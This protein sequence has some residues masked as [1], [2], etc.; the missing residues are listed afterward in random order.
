[1]Q[2]T[3]ILSAIKCLISAENAVEQGGDLEQRLHTNLKSLRSLL[4]RPAPESEELQKTTAAIR[5][6][7]GACRL[8]PGHSSDC[9]SETVHW[10]FA[11]EG[12]CLLQ[13][14]DGTL[15]TLAKEDEDGAPAVSPSPPPAPKCLLSVA[16]L[17][18][19]HSLLQFIV[20]LGV[21]PYLLPGVDTVLRLRLGG[22]QSVPKAATL[23]NGVRNWHLYRCCRVLAECFEN[24]V[25]GA[26]MLSQH[27]CDVLAACL[28]VCY[29]PV[30]GGR[31]SVVGRGLDPGTPPSGEEVRVEGGVKTETKVCHPLTPADIAAGKREQE[32]TA[33]T[34]S[35]ER[36]EDVVESV[37]R[38]HD[39]A[40]RA[41]FISAGEKEQCVALLQKLLNRVYQPLVVRE[42][43]VLQGMPQPSRQPP[44]KTQQEAP[45]VGPG[46]ARERTV[47]AAVRSPRWLQKAC[48]QLLS[49]RLMQKSG[50]RNVLMGVFEAT[51]GERRV[52][53]FLCILAYC[54]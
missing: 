41:R 30:E 38:R 12:L 35:E 1:M 6:E 52:C 25:F 28:Q 4:Q 14:L 45:G 21:Y 48:G 27:F 8:E 7:Y 47:P 19:V 22:A 54:L 34:S 17:K 23:P 44:S 36:S 5:G 9:D 33:A 49:E 42:L 31:G 39:K 2:L 20:S 15:K 32:T 24:P 51:S 16:D 18:S 40:D 53:K 11:V 26:P 3:T 13:V 37:R 50:I 43:L 29:G 46:V 10:T